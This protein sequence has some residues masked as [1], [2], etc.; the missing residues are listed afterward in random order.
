MFQ[1]LAHYL[2]LSAQLL[3]HLLRR[4][5]LPRLGLLRFLHYFHLAEQNFAHLLRRRY[6]ELLACQPVY[7]LLDVGH[8]LRQYLRRFLERRGVKPHAVH[9][10]R[11]QHA[12]QGHLHFT[13]QLP[14]AGLLQPRLQQVLQPQGDVGV[15]GGIL[16]HL[17]G[18]QLA[19]RALAFP[20]RPD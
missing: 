12:H 17:L 2:A 13:E 7:F 19:H 14:H 1:Y 5:I 4:Y 10:H 8:A 15:F 16:I 3:E 9:L 18:L 6:V 11:S 20:L